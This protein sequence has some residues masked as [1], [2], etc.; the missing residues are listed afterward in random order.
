MSNYYTLNQGLNNTNYTERKFVDG[1]PHPYHTNVLN[2]LS[3]MP[4]ISENIAGY[5]PYKKELI[6][7]PIPVI[8]QEELK[9]NYPHEM[10]LP[11]DYPITYPCTTIFPKHTEYIKTKAVNIAP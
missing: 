6:N 5:R 10:L 11:I 9:I 8:K 1:F 7:V 4:I 3:D 2:A